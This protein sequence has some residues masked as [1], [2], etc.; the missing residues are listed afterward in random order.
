MSIYTIT[1]DF[2]NSIE[3]EEKHYL[4][5]ILFIFTNRNNTFKVTKD[6][7]GEVL[8]IYK[9]I[10]P[11]ADIIKTWLE[12]MSFGPSPFEKIDVDISSINC[13]ETKFMKICK[14]T[15]GFNNLI[16]YSA[17]NITKFDCV[18]KTIN[19]E[20]INI[21]ILDRDDANVELNLTR[22]NGDT[23]NNSQV[24]NNG[25]QITKSKN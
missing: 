3:K 1:P 16:V 5:N 19:Y 22:I 8:S 23:Y 15:N 9:S 11:N 24:A 21:N 13:V 7:N 25:S 18:N 6:R 17:Q 2:F 14:E 10:I 4:T 20:G 12:L